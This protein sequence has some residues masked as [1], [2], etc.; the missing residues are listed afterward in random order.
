MQI[1]SLNR[2]F[3]IIL[4]ITGLILSAG[5]SWARS[6]ETRNQILK[7]KAREYYWGIGVPQD[8]SE[9][10]RLYEMAAALGDPSASTIAGGMYFTGKAGVRDP[11]KAFSYLDFGVSSGGAPPE[12]ASALADMY[13][14]GEATPQDF[15][16]AVELYKQAAASGY[17]EAQINLGYLYYTGRGV[18]QDFA[19]SY[20]WFEKA[21]LNSNSM[22]QYN[23]GIMWYTGNNAL[24][25]TSLSDAYA[26]VSIA[27]SNQFQAANGVRLFLERNMSEDQILQAQQRVREIQELISP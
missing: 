21:A 24:N 13:Y 7:Q 3:P 10:L 25:K 11:F 23:L 26:W 1:L 8:Y 6:A 15:S 4:V 16:R 22:A 27:A 2:I 19:Q 14:R 9:S 12:A 17:A 5:H 18:E 20:K